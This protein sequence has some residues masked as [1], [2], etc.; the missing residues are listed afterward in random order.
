MFTSFIPRFN[1]GCLF[2]SFHRALIKSNLG[3]LGEE[4]DSEGGGGG[5]EDEA[6]GHDD[7]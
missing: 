7:K 1:T 2:T 3:D 4:H 6:V 5:E